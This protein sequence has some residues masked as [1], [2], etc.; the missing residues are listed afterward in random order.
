VTDLQ[1]NTRVTLP[2][3]LEPLEEASIEMRRAIH[4]RIFKEFMS[5]EYDEKGKQTPNLLE[6]E[7]K[8]L[9][10]LLKTIRNKELV[11]M[12]TDKSSKFA[13]ATFENYIEMGRKHFGKDKEID[14]EE[15]AE[16]EKV[17]NGHSVM[18]CKMNNAG[19][20]KGHTG[21]IIDCKVS[22]S[23]NP[24]KMYIMYKDHK[25][26][27]STRPVVTGCDSNTRGVVN[28]VAE[29]MEYIANGTK[30]P[31]ASSQQRIIYIES[32]KLMKKSNCGEMK[33]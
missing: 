30:D 4:L 13:V 6:D 8:G 9:N 17:L 18:W 12:K 31:Y 15:L 32:P 22:K 20:R 23:K 33:S 1:E 25:K 5:E 29:F 10:K 3:A 19:E 27:D 24:A 14:V 11:V 7:E 16:H 2:K 21:R 28:T 26:D